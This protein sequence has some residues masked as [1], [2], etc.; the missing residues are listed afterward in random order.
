MSTDETMDKEGE[1]SAIHIREEADLLEEFQLNFS[2]NEEEEE[3]E[4]EEQDLSNSESDDASKGGMGSSVFRVDMVDMAR[5][6]SVWTNDFV[7]APTVFE[8]I[9]VV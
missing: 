6:V 5:S 9:H 2:G 8:G 4:Q 1:Q 3:E 7:F